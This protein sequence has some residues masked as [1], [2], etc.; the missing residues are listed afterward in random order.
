M[1]SVS[2]RVAGEVWKGTVRR[3]MSRIERMKVAVRCRAAK[4][5]SRGSSY[6]PIQENKMVAPLG[7]FDE[8]G[9]FK[10]SDTLWQEILDL[11]LREHSK[12]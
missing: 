2:L 7:S 10:Y 6:K 8:M 9:K 3:L 12:S 1:G 11:G 4:E 5:L